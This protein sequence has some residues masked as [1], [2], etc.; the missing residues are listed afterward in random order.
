[1]PRFAQTYLLK[2]LIQFILISMAWYTCLSRVMDF[3]HH[4]TDVLAGAILGTVIALLTVS[5][6][7]IY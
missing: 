2:H 3:K 7:D 5:D 6:T 1:M 4:P